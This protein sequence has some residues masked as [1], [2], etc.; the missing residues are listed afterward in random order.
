MQNVVAPRVFIAR[1]L[2]VFLLSA[3]FLLPLAGCDLAKN[4]LKV[5]RSSDMEVQDYR[6]ALAER[7]PDIKDKTAVD[8]AGIPEFKPYMATP[9]DKLKP[10][11]LVYSNV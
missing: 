4:S 8:Q 5:D 1:A 11:P 7:L 6:D 2:G 10:M 3:A 9:S